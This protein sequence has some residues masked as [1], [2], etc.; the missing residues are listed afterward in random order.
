MPNDLDW[1]QPALLGGLIV[2]IASAIPGISLINCCFC[3]WALI[4]GAVAAKMTIDNSSRPL[5][6][7]DGARIGLY[8][9]IVAV[10]A[11]VVV[12]IPIILSGVATAVSMRMMESIANSLGNPEVQGQMVELMAT[13]QQMGPL[14]RLASSI[15]VLLVQGVLQGGF[16]VFGGLIGVALFEKRRGELPPPSYPTS[17]F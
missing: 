6:A 17:D 8:A 15:P 14:E 7:G 11:Y 2:G 1:K 4:G 16:T 10:V 3:G 5:V 9:G 13:A 12:A